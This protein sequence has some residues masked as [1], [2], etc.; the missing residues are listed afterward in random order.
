M[1]RRSSQLDVSTIRTR[2]S[3]DIV[4]RSYNDVFS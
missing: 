4:Q 1:D 2:L 3:L